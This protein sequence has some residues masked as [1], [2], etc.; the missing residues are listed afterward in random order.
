[1][2]GLAVGTIT[3]SSAKVTWAATDGA[4]PP[5]DPDTG[6]T[7]DPEIGAATATWHLD[8]TTDV[9]Y[10]A[11][12]DGQPLEEFSPDQ[13]CQDANGHS[14]SPCTAQNAVKYP[15]T[16]LETY[17]PY[18]FRVEALRADGTVARA[19]NGSFTT[20]VGL[21][22][23]SSATTQMNATESSRCAGMGGDFYVTQAARGSVSIPA[24]STQVFG[25][26]YTVPN[27]SCVD[28]FLPPLGNKV[29]KCVDD[30]THLLYAVAP[31]GRG[32]V[33]SSLD[34]VADYLRAPSLVPGSVIEPI[35]WCVESTTCTLVVEE[36]AEAVEMV[37]IGAAAS[38]A[39]SFIVVAAAGIG[40][41]LVLGALLAI[42]FPS[43]IGIG[44]LLEYP[45]ASSRRHE[46]FSGGP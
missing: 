17:T 25:G 11:F 30:L 12:L 44:G 46:T 32:P 41:G 37:E 10:R 42:L 26:C 22:V 29:L 34:G 7:F 33:I 14:V 21:A 16:D 45:C 9:S 38:A 15:I 5:V 27:D 39:A 18:E 43:E 23:V 28:A 20:M 2:S 1:V 24:G 35:T 31:P 4:P 8:P 6:L 13:Y 19:L 40:I 36:A 3:A